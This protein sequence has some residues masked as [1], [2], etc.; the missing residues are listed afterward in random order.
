MTKLPILKLSASSIKTYEQCPRKYWYNYIEKPKIE[1]KE[2]DH[3]TL[4]NFVHKVLE[5][6]HNILI[7]DGSDNHR[8]TMGFVCKQAEQEENYKGEIKYK[9]T[10]EVRKQVRSMLMDYLE[11]LERDGL[12]D[13]QANEDRFNVKLGEDLLI[14]GVID[15][16]DLYNELY[17][18]VDY[19][20]LALDTPIPTPTGWTTMGSLKK[21]DI[22]LGNDGHPTTVVNTSSIHNRPCYQLTF[23]DKTTVVCDNVHL[24][25]V[26]FRDRGS[27]DNYD[28]VL[29]TEELFKKFLELKPGSL[30]IKNHA[31][32]ELPYQNLVINP[33]LL[34]AWLGEGREDLL[35]KNK[36][37]PDQYLRSSFDQRLALLQGLMDI[38]GSWNPLRKRCVFVSARKHL[39]DS[40]AELIRTF[41][42]NAQRFT[43]TDKK[44]F[45]S[46][47]IEFKP[48]GFLP[49]QLPRK[50]NAVK[51]SFPLGSYKHS[52]LALRKKI[53]SIDV[54]KTTPTKCIQVDAP[55][56]LYLCGEGM[57]PTHNTG[58]SKYLDEFQLL[59]YGIALMDKDPKLENYKGSYLVLKENMLWKSYDF[60]KTDVENVKEKIRKVAKQIRNDQTW[61]PRPQFLCSYCDFESICDASPSS[62]NSF[63]GGEIG[64]D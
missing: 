4:G 29:S 25:S 63:K 64:W 60:S 9:M 32:L 3:L 61:E 49:F 2:W 13:V 40:V 23:S 10:P 1:K 62:R 33:W 30:T 34:G 28:K 15:R 47:R 37:I 16:V 46:Y 20:G 50:V 43:F 36:Q 19:K 5:D 58:K 57:V 6:F 27:R 42:V 18:I 12:P 41:G 14:R 31:P 56:S 24:W 11:L 54:I 26:G 55:D 52:Y 17:H 44:G 21:G 51:S 35:N 39:A 8:R 38:K 48:V 22:V 59:V 7:K 45:V 53:R